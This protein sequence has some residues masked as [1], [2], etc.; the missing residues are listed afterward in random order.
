[1]LY[2]FAYTIITKC[3]FW[4]Y[5]T[6]KTLLMSSIL[7]IPSHKPSGCR[8]YLVLVWK[9]VIGFKF[10]LATTG[11]AGDLIV[12]V[13]AWLVCLVGKVSWHKQA[14]HQRYGDFD[15]KS[16]MYQYVSCSD[17]LYMVS[18]ENSFKDSPQ[19]LLTEFLS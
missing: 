3:Y 13:T 19:T 18:C 4:S 12:S 7:S 9:Y 6:L 15:Y 11:T 5:H 16:E 1:M 8:H 17:R 10:T 14:T 2:S